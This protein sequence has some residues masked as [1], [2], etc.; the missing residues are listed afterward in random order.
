MNEFLP[1]ETV[2]A[3]RQ[4]VMKTLLSRKSPQRGW[5]TTNSFESYAKERGLRLSLGALEKWDRAGL[6]HPVLRFNYPTSKRRKTDGFSG[7]EGPPLPEPIVDETEVV[8]IVHNE[9]RP[10]FVNKPEYAHLY[11]ELVQVPSVENFRSN[12]DYNH[13]TR[14]SWVQTGGALYHPLQLFRLKRVVEGCYVSC[15]FLDFHISDGW[16]EICRE[17][18]TSSLD[19]LRDC[20]V[21][22]LQIL[23]LFALIEDKYFPR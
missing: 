4:L 6:M 2:P 3:W 23:Y 5:L 18:I 15:S 13:D 9:W 7:W 1:P 22:D 16:E 20:E 12:R 19:Q 11:D 14:N 21:Q 8:I 17:E 10:E